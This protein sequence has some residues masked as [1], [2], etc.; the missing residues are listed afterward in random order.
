MIHK[1]H[2]WK[3]YPFFC[4]VKERQSILLKQSL[5]GSSQKLNQ[6]RILLI[7]SY[8]FVGTPD[9]HI[10]SISV[11]ERKKPLKRLTLIVSKVIFLGQQCDCVN[12]EECIPEADTG[13]PEKGGVGCRGYGYFILGLSVVG[14]ITR[15]TDKMSVD[16]ILGDQTPVKIARGGG[17]KCCPFYGT[18]RAK[19]LS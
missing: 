13:F 8:I 18:G 9:K 1:Q 6:P 19:C 17:T 5:K 4:Q 11:P 7:H 3:M 10:N 12:L 2:Q 16:K 15:C 14:Y